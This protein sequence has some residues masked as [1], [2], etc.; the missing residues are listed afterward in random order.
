MLSKSNTECIQSGMFAILNPLTLLLLLL[1][2][3]A[4]W[5]QHVN[6]RENSSEWRYIGGDIGH[7]RSTPL[8]QISADNFD[9]LEIE[10]I[11]RMR[12]LGLRHRA[13]P[14]FMRTEN[15]SR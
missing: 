14:L 1:A 10:W 12:V 15:Y 6:E 8:N 3:A 9:E 13:L 7:T 5:G 4:A 2:S 11:W